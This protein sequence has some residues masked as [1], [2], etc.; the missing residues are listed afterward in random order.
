MNQ[1]PA[2][3]PAPIGRRGRQHRQHRLHRRRHPLRRCWA[4]SG[5]SAHI[6]AMGPDTVGKQELDMEL[7]TRARLF[8]DAPDQA[9]TLGECQH[10]FRAGHITASD[11]ITLGHVLSGAVTGRR[12]ADDITIFDS[13]G[14]GLQDL[15][16]G[17]LL[18]A[19]AEHNCLTDTPLGCACCQP[20][21][22]A[23]KSSGSMLPPDTT[24]V[25]CR[26]ATATL[27]LSKA[28]RATAPPGSIT[29]LSCV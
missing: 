19:L 17:R 23:P 11:I 13:T 26:P 21:I 4:G 29:S 24:T 28:A 27:P 18:N 10:A 9:V 20:A 16:A 3:F 22:I 15:A 8:E 5:R 14:M 6:A 1:A 2:A 12:D 25:T 7:I